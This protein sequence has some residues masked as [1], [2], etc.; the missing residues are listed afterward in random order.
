MKV[1]VTHLFMLLALA[2]Y[3]LRGSDIL[4]FNQ[5]C[6]SESPIFPDNS[7]GDERYNLIYN[8]RNLGHDLTYLPDF[9]QADLD[10]LLNSHEILFIPD[11]EDQVNCSLGN[12]AFLPEITSH[13][14]GNYVKNGGKVLITGSSQNV[15]FLNE[16]FGLGLE[17]GGV[18]S[19]GNSI[20]TESNIFGNSFELCPTSI[21]NEDVTFLVMNS[22]GSNATCIYKSNGHASLAFFNVGKGRIGFIGFDFNNTGPDCS[23]D[24]NLWI[25]CGLPNTL[26]ALTAVAPTPTPLPTCS[27]WALVILILFIM[28]LGIV[29]IQSYSLS[30]EFG[31]DT[32]SYE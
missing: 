15:A 22:M 27:E 21:P 13:T 30:V 5:D 12:L 7:C 4:F 31:S 16:V 14:I 32:I 26:T 18:I 2:S 24:E 19:V 29:K 6:N 9:Y 10:S 23:N 20:K 3:S 17:H 25:Q 28:V 11:L 8:L 1:I